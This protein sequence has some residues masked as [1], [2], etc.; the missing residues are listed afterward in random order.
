MGD[1]TI[2]RRLMGHRAFHLQVSV[3]DFS[4]VYAGGC[5]A[6][7]G[8]CSEPRHSRIPLTES[9]SCCTQTQP[10]HSALVSFVPVTLIKENAGAAPVAARNCGDRRARAP[11]RSC[12]RRN[13]LQHTHRGTGSPKDA[14]K[15]Q[16]GDAMVL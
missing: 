6:G 10:K 5:P 7:S 13:L 4:P 16:R 3:L 15:S 2:L 8:G 11:N 14:V 9:R 12:T 1:C